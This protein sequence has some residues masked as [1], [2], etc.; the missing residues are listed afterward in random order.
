MDLGLPLFSDAFSEL[1]FYVVTV[2]RDFVEAVRD[3]LQHFEV[4]Q[5]VC[6][7]FGPLLLESFLDINPFRLLVHPE[8]LRIHCFFGVKY[9]QISLTDFLHDFRNVNVVIFVSAYDFLDLD[10]IVFKLLNEITFNVFVLVVPLEIIARWLHFILELLHDLQKYALV[11]V[12][13]Y[14]LDNLIE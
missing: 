7:D 3:S 5:Y 14:F 8:F 13:L 9:N 10:P 1:V 11:S 12:I 2:F 4:I 6:F